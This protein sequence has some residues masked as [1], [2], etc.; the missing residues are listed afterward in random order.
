MRHHAVLRFLLACFLLYFAWPMIP[1]AV[2]QTA[3]LFWGVWLV[4]F[5]L[6]I[7]ANS[8]T[9]LRITEPP[10]MEQERPRER[11]SF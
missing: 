7:A 6:V 11:Q 4:L 8:A 10:S 1:A 9:I 3:A 5:L 2:T